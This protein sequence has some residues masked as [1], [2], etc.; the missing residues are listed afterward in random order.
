MSF[1]NLCL[2]IVL[3]CAA[4]VYLIRLPVVLFIVVVSCLVTALFYFSHSRLYSIL[5]RK[6]P[7]YY[8]K[9]Y[10]GEEEK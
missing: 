4:V 5:R 1:Y 3:C 6:L 2:P 10:W 7:E 9:F 8:S